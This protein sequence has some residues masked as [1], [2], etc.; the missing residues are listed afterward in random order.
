MDD[1]WPELLFSHVDDA[2][3]INV[4]QYGDQ[5]WLEFD[6]ELIQTEI[7]LARADHLPE[8]FSRAMLAGVLFNPMPQRV[9]LAG[10][11]GG[12]T[13]RYFA[14]RFPDVKGEAVELSAVIVDIA[15]RFFACPHTGNWSLICDDIRQYVQQTTHYYDLIVL[16]IALGQ[17]TPEWLLEPSFL[18]KCKQVLTKQGHLAINLIVDDDEDFLTCL[19]KIRRVFNRR[20]VCLTLPEHSN[21]LVYAFNA[22]VIY[23]HEQR[24]QRMPVLSGEWSVEFEQFYQQM[25]KDNPQGSGIL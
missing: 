20:T 10:A 5:R 24:I 4:W 1:D 7:S 11:G 12:S 19:K 22:P 13:A 17:K 3:P 6:D 18:Y 9:L 8:S 2:H 16:D 15:K 25:I 23:S 14:N 21:I